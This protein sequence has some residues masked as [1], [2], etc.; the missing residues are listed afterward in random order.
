MHVTNSFKNK[1]FWK[2]IIKNLKKLTRK[3]YKKQKGTETNHQ[4]IFGLQNIFIKIPL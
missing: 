1:I 4:S 3:N 2:R